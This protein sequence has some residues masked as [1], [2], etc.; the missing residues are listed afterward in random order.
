[1]ASVPDFS[2]PLWDTEEITP[3]ILEDINER[4]SQITK[5][6]CEKNKEIYALQ[7]MQW[8]RNNVCR[9][10]ELEYYTNDVIKL[11]RFHSSQYDDFKSVFPDFKVCLHPISGSVTNDG[12]DLKVE[13]KEEKKED[14]KEEEEKKKAVVINRGSYEEY[15]LH[16]Q[17]QDYC[18]AALTQMIQPLTFIIV[19]TSH[20]FADDHHTYLGEKYDFEYTWNHSNY[21]YTCYFQDCG[22]YIDASQEG[23]EMKHENKEARDLLKVVETFTKQDPD[24]STFT[25]YKLDHK[26]RLVLNRIWNYYSQNQQKIHCKEE[27]KESKTP[28]IGQVLSDLLQL[29]NGEHS[30]LFL[31]AVIILGTDTGDLDEIINHDHR[32]QANIEQVE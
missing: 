5:M 22:C 25:D 16:Q 27:I 3:E 20:V 15:V 17:I 23:K 14:K 19:S 9:K 8:E 2:S 1:M 32:I 21:T 7:R 30:E 11:F 26:S 6:I 12:K 28:S 4:R 18:H 13:G 24:S 10:K 29:R 31:L